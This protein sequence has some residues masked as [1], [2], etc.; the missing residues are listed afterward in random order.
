MATHKVGIVATYGLSIWGIGDPTLM[1]LI[2]MASRLPGFAP[3]KTQQRC[4]IS[5]PLQLHVNTIVPLGA[6]AKVTQLVQ[7]AS[8][9][10]KSHHRQNRA[11]R[12]KRLEALFA[13]Q[14]NLP[15]A[16]SSNEWHTH[17]ER[18]HDA[19]SRQRGNPSCLNIHL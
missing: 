13:G 1:P 11:R 15:T 10:F 14:T 12:S 17:F 5:S 18:V 7:T 19:G 8:I 3:V 16:T 6:Q 4:S 9:V 2:L